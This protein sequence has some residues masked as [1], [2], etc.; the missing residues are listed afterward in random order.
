MQTRTLA[1]MFFTYLSIYFARKPLSV[2]K[3][4]MQDVLGLS[5]GAI[6]GIDSAF[7]GLYAL[8]QLVL[9]SWAIAWAQR[10]SSSATRSASSPSRRSPRLPR[11][12]RVRVGVNGVAQ[13]LAYAASRS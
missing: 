10:C 2:V 1:L 9:P 5:T 6:A 8:G 3:A 7:L 4:P 11:P 13:S 12:A